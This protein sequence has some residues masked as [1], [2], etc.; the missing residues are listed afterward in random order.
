MYTIKKV[1]YIHG[2]IQVRLFVYWSRLGYAIYN[3]ETVYQ[4]RKYG[5]ILVKLFVDYVMQYLQP[6][7][8]YVYM[9][10]IQ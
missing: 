10:E 6:R 9:G 2:Y 7:N 5:H 3:Q 4:S 8:Y 1:L